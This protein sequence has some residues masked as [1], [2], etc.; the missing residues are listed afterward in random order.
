[1]DSGQNQRTQRF[2]APPG[3]GNNRQNVEGYHTLY[4]GL[5]Y[6][7]CGDNLKVMAGYELASGQLFGTTTDIDSGTWMLG[8]RTFF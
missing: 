6:Y 2:G 4:A 7:L 3:T 1:M 5:N 8:I